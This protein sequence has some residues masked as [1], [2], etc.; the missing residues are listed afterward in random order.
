MEKYGLLVGGAST[1]RFDLRQIVMLKDNHVWSCGG[2][3]G[4]AAKKA[5]GASGF[6][7]MIEVQC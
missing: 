5:R 2:S 3:I 6:N 4:V 7:Q 1:H